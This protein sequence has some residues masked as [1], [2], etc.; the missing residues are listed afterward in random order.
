LP[1]VNALDHVATCVVFVVRADVVFEEVVHE[2][3]SIP[4]IFWMMDFLFAKTNHKTN[5]RA[6]T[7]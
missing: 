3:Y 1:V 7:P 5:E 4:K 2:C 6:N